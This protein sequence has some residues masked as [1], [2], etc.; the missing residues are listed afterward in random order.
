MARLSGLS[1]AVG[2]LQVRLDKMRLE[3]SPK[4]TL[5]I[6][7]FRQTLELNISDLHHN[8]SKNKP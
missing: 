3:G 2:G 7:N 6:K 8:N 1:E 4:R 5:A